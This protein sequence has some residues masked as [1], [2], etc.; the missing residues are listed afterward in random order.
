MSQSLSP[1]ERI[2]AALPLHWRGPG[3]A[4]AVVRN[5]EV[6]VR[7]AWGYADLDRRMPMS[8]QSLMPVCSVTKQFTCGLLLD[9]FPDPSVLDDALGAWLPL[10]EG[11]RPTIA[12]LA[13]NQSGLRDYWALTVLHGALAEGRFD[14]S[15]A[16]ELIGRTRTTHFAPGH[17][18]SYS[19]GNFHILGEIIAER[20]DR[21]L[22][23]LL[24]ERILAPAGMETAR[25]APDTADRPGHVMGYEGNAATG[26][27]PAVNRIW[28]AGDAGLVAS[29]DDLIAW[30]RF[31]D[32]TRDDADGIHARLSRPPAFA[33]G[34]QAYYGF[35]LA[36]AD[37]NGIA[38][39]GHGGALRGWRCHRVHAP[40]ERLSVVVMFNH[41]ANARAAAFSVLD[42]ALGRSPAA[43][44]NRQPG[45]AL[46]GHFLC[47]QTGLS[48]AVT[49]LP[50]G[51]IHFRFGTGAEFLS[52]ADERTA[53]G[54]QTV[55]RVDGDGLL[56]E[57]RFENLFTRLERLP[58]LADEP[59]AGA[60]DIAGRYTS[61]EL[62]AD[63]DI[64]VS[65]GQPFGVFSG[66]LG[67]GT[68]HPL[69]PF[70][71]DV[72]LMPVRRS[73]DAPAPGDFTLRFERDG[74]G[75]VTR[76]EAGCWLARRNLYERA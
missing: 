30:E 49:P 52:P 70:A 37:H 29:L 20:T 12:H 34:R 9:L 58:P 14:R 47:P 8:P 55:L 3:G 32:R 26:F 69:F 73:M 48:A 13:H 76:L 51:T 16:R 71:P 44:E 6:L 31:I 33:D 25:L 65:G 40:A 11:P 17:R 10:M 75:R 60:E 63:L 19:N 21:D 64:A 62:Q 28:W 2:V 18:Y 42:A 7:H 46:K 57:R 54:D 38:T 39:V 24:A 45:E 72:W 4:V 5:G 1:L 22:G 53:S 23:E 15:Q 35:G 67:K 27:F 50:G 43:T 74:R 61:P 41:E 66:F 59:F 36:H 56:L 68:A